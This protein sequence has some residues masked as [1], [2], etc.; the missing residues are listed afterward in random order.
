MSLIFMDVFNC[1]SLG[2]IR[3][4]IDELDKQIVV[5]LAKRGEYVKQAA[6]FKESENSIRDIKRLEQV[7]SKV[8]SVAK[9]IGFEPGIIEQIYRNL[10]EIYIQLE[11]KSFSRA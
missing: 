2:E 3:Y 10:I 1:S 5:L 4:H 8:T 9:E 11:T 7:I 6:K